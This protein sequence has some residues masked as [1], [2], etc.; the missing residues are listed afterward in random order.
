MGCRSGGKRV[1]M[2]SDVSVGVGA[3]DIYD[4]D[5]FVVALTK[6]IASQVRSELSAERCTN[7]GCA[8]ARAKQMFRNEHAKGSLPQLTPSIA[9]LT[10]ARS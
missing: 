1:F 6:L 8:Y 5:D 4:E 7:R 2:E 9:A 10:H 3:H